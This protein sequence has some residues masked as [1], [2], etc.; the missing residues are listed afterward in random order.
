MFMLLKSK[1]KWMGFV[2]IGQERE[3][4]ELTAQV[5]LSTSPK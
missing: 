2:Q 3:E 1:P 4:F 5:E